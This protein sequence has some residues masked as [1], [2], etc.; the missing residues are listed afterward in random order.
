MKFN[1]KLVQWLLSIFWAASFS[2]SAEPIQKGAE[3]S[4][5]NSLVELHYKKH[6]TLLLDELRELT[7]IPGVSVSLV[8]HGQSPISLTSGY[9]DTKNHRF[10]LGECF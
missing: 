9:V 6:L 1:F 10:S 2:I 7:G 4:A 5:K 8:K 3:K